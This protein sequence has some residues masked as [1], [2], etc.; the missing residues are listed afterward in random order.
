MRKI[1]HNARVV[2]VVEKPRKKKPVEEYAGAKTEITLE[3]YKSRVKALRSRKSSVEDIKWA[4][5]LCLETNGEFGKDQLNYLLPKTSYQKRYE[6][7]LSGLSFSIPL[8]GSINKKLEESVF[9]TAVPINMSADPIV[10]NRCDINRKKDAL[11]NMETYLKQSKKMKNKDRISKDISF[12]AILKKL[13]MESP[14]MKTE[15]EELCRLIFGIPFEHGEGYE[16]MHNL[17]SSI[18][19]DYTYDIQYREAQVINKNN[20]PRKFVE[21]K[22]LGDDS[23]MSPILPKKCNRCQYLTIYD[24]ICGKNKYTGELLTRPIFRCGCDNIYEAPKYDCVPD[25]KGE[26]VVVKENTT[27]KDFAESQGKYDW[28]MRKMKCGLNEA[29]AISLDLEIIAPGDRSSKYALM[30]TYTSWQLCYLA[31]ELKKLNPS[32][33][34]VEIE[35][36]SE[37]FTEQ[38][39]D[40]FEIDSDYLLY[41]DDRS[42]LNDAVMASD[43]EIIG[44]S[45][46]KQFTYEH[47]HFV[48][49]SRK[50]RGIFSRAETCQ[51]LIDIASSMNWNDVNWEEYH[52]IKNH[53]MSKAKTKLSKLIDWIKSNKDEAKKVLVKITYQGETF[54]M[55]KLN[56]DEI[57]MLWNAYKS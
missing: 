14:S 24:K 3:W 40:D 42:E 49:S 31:F 5:G 10:D 43:Y 47:P 9:K 39:S 37:I 46:V 22:K 26:Y 7:Y 29:I 38:P 13:V 48:N 28:I 11:K 45:G 19:N 33:Q 50:D 12:N 35:S 1:N 25:M 30:E 23:F 52:E 4:I 15:M 27:I 57:A 54:G 18:G 32:V 8:S 55:P 56:Q 44:M 51:E 34:N 21:Y 6:E 16:Y 36:Y 20:V 53:L 2:V 17:L 41:A